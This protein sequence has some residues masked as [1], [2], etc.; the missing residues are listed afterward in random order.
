MRLILERSGGFT[1]LRRV[2]RLE[3]STLDPAEER[4]L[5]DAAERAAVFALPRELRA[6]EP[7][8]DRF[9]YRLEIEDAGRETSVR[10]DEAAASEAL[11]DLVDLVQDLADR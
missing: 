8:P 3:G 6:S 9:T 7:R 5:R 4:C 10:F 1:G 11:L 2:A